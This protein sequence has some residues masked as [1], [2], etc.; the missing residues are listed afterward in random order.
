MKLIKV[1]K[2]LL[3]F[4]IINAAQKLVLELLFL[5]LSTKNTFVQY[6]EKYKIQLNTQ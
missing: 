3:N 6:T 1:V 5:N 2:V 4:L